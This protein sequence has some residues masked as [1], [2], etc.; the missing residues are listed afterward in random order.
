MDPNVALLLILV[1]VPVA[2]VLAKLGRPGSTWIRAWA[3]TAVTGWIFS[4]F[5]LWLNPPG[6]GLAYTV[7]FGLG[8][9][10]ALPVTA[11]LW[12]IQALLFRIKPGIR[13]DAGFQSRCRIG[14]DLS[15]VLAL[16]LILD[17]LFGWI[18]ADRAITIAN[19]HFSR[20]GHMPPGTTH[21]IWSWSNWTVQYGDE[22][23]S[24][25]EISRTGAVTGGY[26]GP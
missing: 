16:L 14:A 19:A 8:W 22:S 7:A 3:I 13:D 24:G 17:G 18:S 23:G 11:V 4:T 15:R 10:W 26:V 9:I 2:L 12:L 1:V 6:N 20:Q 25:I 5:E 21:A